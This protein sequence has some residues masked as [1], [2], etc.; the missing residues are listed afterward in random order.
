[1]VFPV[2]SLCTV[3]TFLQGAVT[4]SAAAVADIR[5]FFKDAAFLFAEIR[6]EPVAEDAVSAFL[7]SPSRK[8]GGADMAPV[9]VGPVPAGIVI[10]HGSAF[11]FMDKMGTYL[12]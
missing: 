9:T 4:L 6:T 3:V 8:T 5:R 2:R 7:K 11:L 10:P 12:P 1:M